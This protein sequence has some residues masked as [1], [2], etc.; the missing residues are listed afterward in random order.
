MSGGYRNGMESIDLEP[1]ISGEIPAVRAGLRLAVAAY[2]ARYKGQSRMH[3]D[4][5]L[6]GFLDRCQERGLD[7]LTVTRLH[8]ELYRAGC[9]KCATSSPRPYPAGS[10]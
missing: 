7:P 3:S 5:D 1:A 6:R 8:V 10:Q 2:L 4:S 9:K